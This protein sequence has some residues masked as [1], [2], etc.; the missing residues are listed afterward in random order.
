MVKI[1]YIKKKAQFPVLFTYWPK[2]KTILYL[3]LIT[4]EQGGLY[5]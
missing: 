4:G 5:E 1:D 2:K 3:I